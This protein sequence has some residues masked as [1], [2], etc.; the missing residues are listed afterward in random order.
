MSNLDRQLKLPNSRPL[1]VQAY[2]PRRVFRGIFRVLAVT[3]S[4]TKFRTV[5]LS[6]GDSNTKFRTVNLSEWDSN[7]KFHTVNLS[8]GIQH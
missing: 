2:P 3:D 8:A 4:N 7:T 1:C 5:N 6:A